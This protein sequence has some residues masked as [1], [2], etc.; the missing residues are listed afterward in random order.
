[1]EE[2]KNTLIEQIEK[3]VQQEDL[4]GLDRLIQSLDTDDLHTYKTELVDACLD[5]FSIWN[6]DL[7]LGKINKEHEEVVIAD[8]FGILLS[9]EKVDPESG[10]HALRARLYEHIA[11][12]KTERDEKLQNIQK[13]IDE[14]AIVLQKEPSAEMKARLGSAMLDRMQ[15]TQQFTEGEFTAALQL[16]QSAFAGW[17]ESVFITFLHGCFQILNF[18]CSDNI[19][20]HTLFIRQMETSLSGFAKTDPIIYLT[21]ST[22]LVRVLE[23]EQYAIPT[24]YG[25]ELKIRSIEL[26]EALTDYATDDTEWL[27]QLGNAFEKAAKRMN[28]DATAEKIRYYEIALQYFIKGQTINPATWTF[29]VYATNVQMALARMY[30]QQHN[31]AEVRSLFEAGKSIFSKTAEY[32]KDFTLMQYWGEFLIEYARLA[33]NFNAPAILKEAESKLLIA[34]ELGRGFYSHPFISLAKVA[35]KGGDKQRCLT[36]LQECKGVFTT[37][38]Y[39]YDFADFLRDEDFREIW[40]EIKFLLVDSRN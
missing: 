2:A 33:Y 31:Q 28:V 23:Y 27:N 30:F 29:P 10:Q 18:S 3:L 35:L 25:D 15:I 40:A 8:L 36:I 24:A 1:M 9:A 21:W 17:S 37:E 32:G 22:E 26:L 38:Y 6:L 14:Y 19:H 39:Q 4:G 34:K 7:V 13:A 12:I 20:W 16:L 5:I 11:E